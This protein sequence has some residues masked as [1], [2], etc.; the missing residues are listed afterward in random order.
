MSRTLKLA[1]TL[2]LLAAAL[3]YFSH[4]L[5]NYPGARSAPSNTEITIART[6]RSWAIPKE[7]RTA[8]NPFSASPELLTESAPLRRPLRLLPLQ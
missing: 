5:E 1:L 7:A 4:V 6:L 3:V 8:K 2:L